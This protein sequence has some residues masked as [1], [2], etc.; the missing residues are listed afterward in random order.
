MTKR[1]ANCGSDKEPS[2][3]ARSPKNK[4]GLRTYCKSCSNVKNKKYRDENPEASK[5]ATSKWYQRNKDKKAAQVKSWVERNKERYI[6]VGKAWQESNPELMKSY[7]R[8]HYQK[9][10]KR[11]ASYQVHNAI[12]A[13]LRNC[14]RGKKSARTEE[15]IGY[16][17]EELM[18]SIEKQFRPGMSWA[19]YGD[20][21]IDH[22][23]PLIDFDCSTEESDE[24]R[25][26]WAISNLRPI[27]AEENLRKSCKRLYLL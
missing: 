22:I 2:E 10:R 6:A 25:K 15:L 14:L 20:W 9:N 26:A 17:V 4:D 24:I 27:W 21:H 23:V 8:K 11:N 3:F 7:W 12:G 18:A 16:Q 5:A 1:C 13:R 19:N